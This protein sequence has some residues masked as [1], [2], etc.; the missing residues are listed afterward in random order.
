ML[1]ILAALN[2][3]I[4]LIKS[5]ME[6]DKT[7]RLRNFTLH[8]G[9]FCGRE[10]A[11][12]RTGVGKEAMKYAISYCIDE[13]KPSLLI[14]IG[15]AGGLDPRLNAGDIVVATE[16]IDEKTEESFAMDRELIKTM[17]AVIEKSDIKF[18]CGKIVTVDTP[19]TD[20]HDKAFTGTKFDAI[21]CDME[22]APFAEL[23]K[24]AGVRSAIV[25]SI[26]DPLDTSLPIFPDDIMISGQLNLGAL[27]GHI[28]SNPKDIF[29]LPKFSY[30]SNQARISLTNFLKAWVRNEKT[31]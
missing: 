7:V 22:S 5:E 27:A 11:L 17:G 6:I 1:T 26:L 13:I 31:V 29:K 18:K 23:S 12:V 24:T 10:I 21:A 25:R 28:K 16:A 14:N 20:P 30:L 9:K 4:K 8:T 19:L 2:D 3:E 15:Y